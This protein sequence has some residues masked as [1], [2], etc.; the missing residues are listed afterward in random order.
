MTRTTWDGPATTLP[1]SCSSSPAKTVTSTPAKAWSPSVTTIRAALGPR[2]PCFRSRMPEAPASS[3]M[4]VRR[5][6]ISANSDRLGGRRHDD[7]RGWVHL[8]VSSDTDADREAERINV[9]WRVVVAD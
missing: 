2:A 7:R 9:A 8:D 3:Y 6:W 4:H 1:A 5:D